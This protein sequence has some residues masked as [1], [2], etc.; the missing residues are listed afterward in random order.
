MTD[1]QLLISAIS[2]ARG[3]ERTPKATPFQL[4]SS[5]VPRPS[6]R[7]GNKG[8]LRP[9][10]ATGPMLLGELPM[11]ET[12]VEWRNAGARTKQPTPRIYA[13]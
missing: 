1:A 2:A 12:E 11:H 6:L 5:V 3:K 4:S 10:P 8:D 13:F 9:M 7:N